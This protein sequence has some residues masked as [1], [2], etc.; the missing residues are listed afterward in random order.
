MGDE[1]TKGGL[2]P[3]IVVTGANGFIGSWVCRTLLQ[4]YPKAK[5][6]GVGRTPA[7]KGVLPSSS[8]QYISCDLITPEAYKTLP[9]TA[10][11]IIHLAGDRRT[12][13]PHKD[14]AGQFMVNSYMTSMLAEYAARVGT[15]L[16][17]YASS[18]YIYSGCNIPF[19][20]H[21]LE[22][23]EE[24]LGAS[25]LA[26][27][28]LLKAWALTG[29]FNVLACRIFTV[30]GPG[31][32]LKQ[33]IPQAIEKLSSKENPIRF[34]AGEIQRDFIYVKDIA[35]ALSQAVNLMDSDIG[36]EAVNIGSGKGTRI[37]EVIE[38]L[39][40]LL[41]VNKEVCYDLLSPKL[42]GDTDHVA[43]IQKAALLLNWTPQYSL[44]QGLK[45]LLD[46]LSKE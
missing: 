16:F 36:F 44:E 31:S 46:T 26:A 27:E 45:D 30:Y 3:T 41:T 9:T 22:L 29:Q 10:D 8:F 17:I 12:F 33:F 13:V 11:I 2:M 39:S 1:F 25:K 28:A 40:I 20:E 4:K 24:M 5:V 38:T 37:R 35:D 15:Q 21:K 34:G 6:V 18:V 32:N 19:K 43:N 42:S 14:F 23:P 7:W